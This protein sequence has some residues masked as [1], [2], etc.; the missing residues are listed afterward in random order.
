V[1]SM[2]AKLDQKNPYLGADLVTLVQ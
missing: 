1:R 2:K